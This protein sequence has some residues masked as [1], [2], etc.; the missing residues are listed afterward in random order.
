MMQPLT[1]TD[2]GT[3]CLSC[4]QLSLLQLFLLQLSLL[5]FRA[6]SRRFYPKRLTI[7][8]FVLKS[9]TIYLCR[10]SKVTW[11]NLGRLNMRCS[12]TFWIRCNGLITEAG[13]P[14]RSELQYSRR[15]MTSTR[16]PSTV[17]P[18]TV[19]AS[20]FN[21]LS[22]NC[23]SLNSHSLSLQLSQMQPS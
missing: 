20:A 15:E 23:L 10:Y 6:L 5:T 8:T 9:E 21:C 2:T 16:F 11:E 18:S 1:C 17:S 14:A 12:A 4:L 7:S 3:D 19:S 22:F 13:T